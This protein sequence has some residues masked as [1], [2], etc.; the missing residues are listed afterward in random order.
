ML[1]LR[2]YITSPT[3]TARF[4]KID[5]INL[6]RRQSQSERSLL[7]GI[8]LGPAQTVAMRWEGNEAGPDEWQF[9][10]RT[11]R[12]FVKPE[13]AF[14][15]ASDLHVRARSETILRNIFFS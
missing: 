15:A 8:S 1:N 14:A 5:V 6:N 4:K 12:G 7:L 9:Q 10:T 3:K 2:S 11:L 13:I